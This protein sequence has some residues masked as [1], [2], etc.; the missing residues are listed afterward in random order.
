MQPEQMRVANSQQHEDTSISRSA[1]SDGSSRQRVD[2]TQGVSEVC[3][4]PGRVTYALTGADDEVFKQHVLS[5]QQFRLF[6]V[7]CAHVRRTSDAPRPRWDVKPALH[8]Y[9]DHGSLRRCEQSRPLGTG[10]VV[11]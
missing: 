10:T 9:F 8:Q 1:A 5:N 2:Q 7:Q 4:I 3:G 6:P 11:E